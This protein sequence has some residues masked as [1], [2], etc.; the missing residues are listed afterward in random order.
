M[1]VLFFLSFSALDSKAASEAEA[2]EPM[3]LTLAFNMAFRGSTGEDDLANGAILGGIWDA[4]ASQSGLGQS[5]P[6]LAQ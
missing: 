3:C 4:R 1:F 5:S 2:S 6:A